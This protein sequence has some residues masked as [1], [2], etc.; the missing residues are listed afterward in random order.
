MINV[1]IYAQRDTRWGNNKLGFSNYLLKDKGCL[2]TALA[3][4]VSSVYQQNITPDLTN[5][6]LKAAGAFSGGLLYWSKVPTAFPKFK[7]VKRVRG[8]NNAEVS[9]YVY[10]KKIPVLVEVNA[11]SIGAPIHWVLFLGDRKMM[12]PWAGSIQS[13]AKY[14]PT[15]YALY[16]T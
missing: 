1:P 11:W 16:Q 6:K 15:G 3:S 2:V 7:W 14:P 9:T 5:N 13:T 12:D 10:T 8:Y 4:F